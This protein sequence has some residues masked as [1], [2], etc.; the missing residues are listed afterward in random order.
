MDRVPD[1]FDTMALK[2]KVTRQEVLEEWHERVAIRMFL[3]GMGE[4]DAEA[5]AFED[6][7]RHFSRQRDLLPR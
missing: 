3:G 7:T 4:R 5:G 2:L 1:A 6:V